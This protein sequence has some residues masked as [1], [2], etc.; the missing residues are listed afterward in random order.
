MF[1]LKNIVIMEP[2]DANKAPEKYNIPTELANKAGSCGVKL[3][4]FNE[5][6]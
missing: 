4:T 6:I 2:Y 5:V 3:Y 1:R